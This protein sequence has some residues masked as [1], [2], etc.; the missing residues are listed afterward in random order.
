MKH[1]Q[2]ETS[3]VPR[4]K[5]RR[6]TLYAVEKPFYDLS[7]ARVLVA[8]RPNA[9]LITRPQSHRYRDHTMLVQR[10]EIM[11]DRL[12]AFEHHGRRNVLV[13]EASH[14]AG[15][16]PEQIHVSPSA[17]LEFLPRE[18]AQEKL[19]RLAQGVRQAE[20]VLV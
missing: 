7:L 5:I 3:A 13:T 15:L 6:V 4:H 18:V 10:Q 1:G 9:K 12:L 19:R 14:P 20:A 16:A 2:I 8:E 17:G 11:P